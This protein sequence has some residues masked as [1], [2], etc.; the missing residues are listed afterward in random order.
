M[1][2]KTILISLFLSAAMTVQANPITRAEAR[3]VAQDLVGINDTSADDVPVSPYYIF[4]RGEGQGFVIASGD[5][6]TAPILGYTETGDFD[7]SLLPPQLTAMLQLWEERIGQVQQSRQ[8]P[9]LRISAPRRAIPS[10][11]QNWTD[12]ATLVQTHWHQ[13]SPYNDMAPIKSGV[14][15]CLAGC[16]ATAGSQ[17]TYYFHKDNPSELAYATPTYSYGTPITVS[18]P[19]GTPIEWDQMKLSGSGTERQNK[20]VATLVYALGTSAWLTYGDGSGTATSGHNEKMAEAMRG[21]FMLN[22]AHKWK[23]ESTQQEWEELIYNNL[24]T[25]R[26]MLYSGAN[27]EGGHSVVLDGYQ[28]STGL[29]HFNFGWGG[30]G[31]GYYTVDDATGMNGFNTYQDLV[32]NITPQKQS[33]DG[34]VN[35]ERLYH[36][37]STD[38]EITVTNTGTLDYQGIYLYINKQEKVTSQAVGYDSKT[39]L[40]PGQSITLTFPVTTTITNSAY[41]LVCDKSRNIIVSRQVPVDSTIAALHMNDIKVDAGTQQT[42]VD[43]MVFRTVNNL[44]ATVTASLTNG[45]G[46]TYCQP[47]LQCFLQRYNSTTKK[48]ASDANVIAKDIVFG[49]GQTRDAEFVFP[50]L[51]EG[52]YYRAYMNDASVASKQTSISIDTPEPFV[53]FM[54]RRANLNVT[55]SGR[56]AKVTGR[57][58]STIFKQKAASKTICSYDI[59][60]LTELNEKPQAANPNALFFAKAGST[61]VADIENVVVGDVC[62]N[63]T[64]QTGAD[65]KPMKPFTAQHASLQLTEAEPGK[66]HG[67]LIPF[68]AEVPYGIQMKEATS[69][70]SSGL[71]TVDH[72]AT[73]QVQPMT[74]VTYLTSRTGL[75]TVSAT[76]VS[77]TTDTLISMFSGVLRASTLSTP[78][79]SVSLVLGEYINSLYYNTPPA[80]QTTV[81]AFQ[82]YLVGVTAQHVRTTSETA[83][84]GYYRNLS[85]TIDE[86]YTALADHP[87]V[88]QRAVAALMAE[89]TVAQ[90]MLTYRSHVENNDVKNERDVLANAIKAFLDVAANGITKGD[91]NT[92]GRVDV[93]DIATVL[94]VMAG[95]Q[96]AATFD[97][98][99]VNAD[100]RVDVADIATVLSIMASPMP[101]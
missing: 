3:Q 101:H 63:M 71:A 40:E 73:R 6:S 91:V 84:D 32:Y 20:A 26:P 53:Y 27:S 83:V 90:D 10:Y 60:G 43:D 86:A 72:T 69:Y 93:A 94:S 21:Q 24:S 45:E 95:I 22:S 52:A 62:K 14:G 44:S 5:D 87:S 47:T 36:K 70:T 13:S 99:D 98:A 1:K 15:R 85:L 54:V 66:W 50:N 96:S 88:P 80:D 100:G 41:L 75:D 38:V 81:D 58:N 17:V 65:F 67:A 61:E 12:V 77:I 48:W 97:D 18:L 35:T 56:T 9:S 92:D 29:Y 46:G 49:E 51:V 23:S 57:W 82:P 33:L 78:L 19:A 89:I 59:S 74:V 76:D 2:P 31:D 39:V 28:A 79:P 64:I 16:V 30:Q 68:A 34:S 4:S 11:K 8:E 37:A 42:T 7:P 25:R 55:Y